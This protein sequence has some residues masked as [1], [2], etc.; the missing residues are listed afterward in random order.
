VSIRVALLRADSFHRPNSI[1]FRIFNKYTS[2]PQNN[3]KVQNT[4]KIG[5]MMREMNIL[6]VSEHAERC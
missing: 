4:L 2:V 1:S 5:S 3:K 6:N